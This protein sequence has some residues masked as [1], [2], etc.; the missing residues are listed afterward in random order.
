M[1]FASRVQKENYRGQDSNTACGLMFY[2]HPDYELHYKYRYT[3]MYIYIY[4]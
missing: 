2:T 3:N 4:T 1:E